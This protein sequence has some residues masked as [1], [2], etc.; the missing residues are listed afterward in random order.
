MFLKVKRDTTFQDTL[1]EALKTGK[2]L[3]I[4]RATIARQI[5]W[6]S[7]AARR[8]RGVRAFVLHHIVVKVYSVMSGHMQLAS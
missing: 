7:L 2:P 3:Q 6:R 4:D 8:P 1:A 5:Q